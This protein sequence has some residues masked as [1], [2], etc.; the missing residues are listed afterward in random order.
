[1]GDGAGRRG[2]RNYLTA[3]DE[4]MRTHRNG[5]PPSDFTVVYH[6]LSFDRNAYVR[7]KV[8]LAESRLSLPSIVD[9]WPAANWYERKVWDLFGIVFDGHPH[10]RRILMPKSWAGH[11]LRKDHP[12]TIA[13]MR[14]LGKFR[15]CAFIQPRQ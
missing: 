14:F 13:S 11:P 3:I 12:A 6:L 9:I 15:S 10:L 5:Q 7:I 2:S 4:R 8:A 1:M